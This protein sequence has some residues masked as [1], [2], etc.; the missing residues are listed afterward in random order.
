MSD[1]RAGGHI[2]NLCDVLAATPYWFGEGSKRPNDAEHD[3]LPEVVRP[4]V[5]DQKW[6]SGDS[7]ALRSLAYAHYVGA[8]SED[9]IQEQLLGSD[10][11]LVDA[12]VSSAATAAVPKDDLD[13]L[14]DAILAG[15]G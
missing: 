10:A 6:A 11:D 13:P 1:R 3:R 12:V 7:D 9:E 2:M 4:L 14:I 8:L 5:E 15:R